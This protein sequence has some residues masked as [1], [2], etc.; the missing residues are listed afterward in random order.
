MKRQTKEI[1]EKIDELCKLAE[2]H[3]GLKKMIGYVRWT[4]LI[5]IGGKVIKEGLPEKVSIEEHKK[6]CDNNGWDYDFDSS[7]PYNP[8]YDQEYDWDEKLCEMIKK[9]KSK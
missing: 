7:N 3:W 8:E 1:Q 6:L 5:G 4:Q 2:E 9:K